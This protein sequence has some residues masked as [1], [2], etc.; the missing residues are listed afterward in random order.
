M[1]ELIRKITPLFVLN[2]YHYFLAFTGALFYGFPSKRLKVIAVTGTKGKSSVVDMIVSIFEEAG[3]KTGSISSVRFKIKDKEWQNRLK[4]TMPGRMKIQKFLKQA[5][6]EGCQY[7]ILETTSEGIKQYRHKFINFDAAVLTN[8]SPEHIE[9]HGSYEKYRKAK[10]E[11]FKITRNIHI[12][13]SDEKDTEYFL[14]VPADKKILYGIKDWKLELGGNDFIKAEDLK[15]Y[16]DKISFKVNGIEFNMNLLG[17]FNALN[18]LAAISTALSYGISYE[19]I[20]RGL[21][22][23]KGIKGRMEVVVKEPFS[24]IVDYAHT[25]DSLLK[26]YETLTSYSSDISVLDRKPYQ[27]N[28]ICVLGACGGGRDKWKRPVM[29]KIAA[30]HCKKIILTNEDPYDENHY[31]ILSMVKS[32]ILES[33]FKKSDFCEILDRREAIRKALEMAR[34]DDVVIITGKGSEPWMC[35]EKGKKIPWDDRKVVKEEFDKI[36]KMNI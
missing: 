12:I 20:K 31:E 15:T 16:P 33:D 35:V 21:E 2:S 28:L 19:T 1:K 25:P 29:G 27:S 26:V 24:V 13:N 23:I 10:L 34:Q 17:A 11:L 18:A 7:F 30:N 8:L 5:L 22:K 14:E 4:M 36:K 32:G 3:Y 6:N 9:S